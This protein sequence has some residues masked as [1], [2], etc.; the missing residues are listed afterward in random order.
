VVSGLKP[1]ATINVA[2]NGTTTARTPAVG[3]TAL[4]H[5]GKT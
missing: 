1:Y 2:Y 3:S 4:L 5:F